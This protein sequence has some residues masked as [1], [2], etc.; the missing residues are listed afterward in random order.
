MPNLSSNAASHQVE[1]LS[2]NDGAPKKLNEQ[3]E[4]IDGVNTAF[5]AIK[6]LD[7]SVLGVTPGEMAILLSKDK[8]SPQ[9]LFN[10]IDS[11]SDLMGKLKDV[12]QAERADFFSGLSS[13]DQE[14]MVT[15]FDSIQGT[16]K[17]ESQKKAPES[18]QD[19]LEARAESLNEA[20]L[21]QV[22]L[23]LGEPIPEEVKIQIF[24]KIGGKL[25]HF[26]R[27]GISP[28]NETHVQALAAKMQSLVFKALAAYEKDKKEDEE[29]EVAAERKEK[30]SQEREEATDLKVRE[31]IVNGKMTPLEINDKINEIKEKHSAN[32]FTEEEI[33]KEVQKLEEIKRL[34]EEAN[35]MVKQM[36]L[37]DEAKSRVSDYI[38][39]SEVDIGASNLGD[40]FSDAWGKINEDQDLTDD[41]KQEMGEALGIIPLKPD[42]VRSGADLKK[43]ISEGYGLDINGETIPYS[44]DRPLTVREGVTAYP[45]GDDVVVS[46]MYKGRAMNFKFDTADTDALGEKVNTALITM[47]MNEYNLGGFILG[48]QGMTG[49]ETGGFIEVNTDLVNDAYIRSQKIMDN[50]LGGTFSGDGEILNESELDRIQ[51]A[52]QWYLEPLPGNDGGKDEYDVTKANDSLKELGV[53]D[54]EGA[55]NESRFEQ[56]LDF[57]SRYSTTGSP[58]YIALKEHLHAEPDK[59]DVSFNLEEEQTLS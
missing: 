15:A 18:A 32:G 52:A 55:L 23:T 9:T 3:R 22:E 40:A 36:D 50:L 4:R 19:S 41:Q 59:P 24:A 54:G 21:T 53:L 47:A 7:P 2:A 39:N 33:T 42:P 31:V 57:I 35:K 27:K 6:G 28:A 14:R 10:A 56:S 11:V 30:K 58:D 45:H 20:L 25:Q 1:Q 34:V 37:S 44:K 8:P 48:S 51:W 13:E 38:N 12:P 26:I 49:A 5:E 17:Q 46:A 43:E 29:K 16:L